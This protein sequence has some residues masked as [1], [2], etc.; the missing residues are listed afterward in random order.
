[1]AEGLLRALSN[2]KFIVFSAGTV[3]TS[4]RKEAVAAMSE[5]GIDISSHTSKTFEQFLEVPFAYLITV[6]DGAHE[7]CPFTGWA[8]VKKRMH[9]SFE[10]PSSAQGT[11]EEKLS[12]FRKVRD[13]IKDRIETFLASV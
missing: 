4:V 3:A 2:G 8:Q 13:E 10:D 7:N 12:A 1:M 5:I 11:D 9:W 6:C